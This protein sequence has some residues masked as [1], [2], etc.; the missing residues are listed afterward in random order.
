MSGYL[1]INIFISNTCSREKRVPFFFVDRLVERVSLNNWKHLLSVNSSVTF[2][3]FSSK[4]IRFCWKSWSIFSSLILVSRCS[5]FLFINS[6]IWLWLRFFVSSLSRWWAIFRSV[7]I[8]FRPLP[9]IYSLC[10]P[11]NLPQLNAP[12]IYHLKVISQSWQDHLC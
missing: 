2:F 7:A 8:S 9:R 1:L 4:I 11:Q 3:S 12:E 10:F 5:T 6:I